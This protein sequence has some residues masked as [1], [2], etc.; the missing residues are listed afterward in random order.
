MLE[1]KTVKTASKSE[2]SE[3]YKRIVKKMSAWPDWKKR[4]YNEAFAISAHAKK[5][6]LG[7]CGK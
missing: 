2:Y 4:E 3:N 7:D 5:L 1:N 6:T